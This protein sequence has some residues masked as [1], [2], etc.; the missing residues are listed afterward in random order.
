MPEAPNYFAETRE[1][2]RLD[3]ELVEAGRLRKAQLG[4]ACR[5]EES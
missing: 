4:A 3:W 1:S 2:V 5:P